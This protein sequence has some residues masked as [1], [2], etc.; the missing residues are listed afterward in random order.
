[1][2]GFGIAWLE[3]RARFRSGWG[4]VHRQVGACILAYEYGMVIMA[5]FGNTTPLPLY[6][7]II[8]DDDESH[9]SRTLV[10]YST[11]IESGS[12]YNFKGQEW[13]SCRHQCFGNYIK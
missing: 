3:L 1:V 8:L 2:Y 5:I 10:S 12:T 11:Q 13:F 6:D 9:G 4:R 7:Y